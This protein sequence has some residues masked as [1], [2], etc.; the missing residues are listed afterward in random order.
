[1]K[2]ES[3]KSEEEVNAIMDRYD[4]EIF[5]REHDGVLEQ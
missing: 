4:T 3:D 1:M 2:T 5:N